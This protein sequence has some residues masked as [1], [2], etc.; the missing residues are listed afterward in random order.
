MYI[1]VEE[2]MCSEVRF[3]RNA[4]AMEAGELIFDY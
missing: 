2:L 4:Q 3:P 1:K